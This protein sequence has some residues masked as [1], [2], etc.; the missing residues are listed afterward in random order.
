MIALIFVAWL[1]DVRL[2]HQLAY[3]AACQIP[4]ARM[5]PIVGNLFEILFLNAEETFLYMRSIASGYKRS[6]RFWI[7]GILHYHAIR[8]TDIEVGKYK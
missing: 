1:I 7:F 3:T 8:A 6:N 5:Y 2:R 4:G